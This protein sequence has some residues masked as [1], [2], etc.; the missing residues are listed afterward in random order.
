MYYCGLYALAPR[1]GASYSISFFLQLMNQTK[2]DG[3]TFK[4]GANRLDRIPIALAFAIF[5]AY[6]LPEWL[7]FAKSGAYVL[8][9]AWD[10]ETYLTWQGILGS[11]NSPGYFV[12]YLNWLL[13]LAGLSG[14]VQNLLY[15]TCL[16]PLTVFF[17]YR[18]LRTL[19]IGPARAFAYA[20][21][22]C[23]SSTLFNYANPLVSFLLGSY[24]ATGVFMAGWE[25]YPSI[26]RTP[27]PQ[28]SYLL[29]SAAV[30]GF[31]KFRKPW[32]LALPLPLLYY[33]VA[34]PYV[35]ALTTALAY[36]QMRTRWLRQP[37]IAV[38][39]ATVF[40]FLLIG[41]GM[42][43]LS[44]ATG[45][46]QPDHPYRANSYL[47][48]NTRHVQLPLVLL[49]MAGAYLLALRFKLYHEKS[50]WL[51]PLAVLAGTALGSINLHI[52]M[53]FMLS[54]KGYYDYGLSIIFGLALAIMIDML[55]NPVAR[56]RVL[57]FALATVLV[58]TL[59]SQVYWYTQA[60]RLSRQLTPI[61][62]QVRRDPLHAIIPDLRLSSRVA[63]SSPMLL[64]PPFSYQYYF[65]FIE[66]QCAS[67]RATLKHGLAFAKSQ[68]P[69]GSAD[70]AKL[71][72]TVRNIE[73]GQAE[74]RTLPFGNPPYCHAMDA[75]NGNFM[76][77]SNP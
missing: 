63:Y 64:A 27:N 69:A 28:V 7:A 31:L 30:Y 62:G 73:K 56:D 3:K 58:P 35:F 18:S 5:L 52:I 2:H 33:F 16:P 44:W 9:N 10:E 48:V 11:R 13:H 76:L 74:S 45:L 57:A 36:Q 43:I 37:A 24:D 12:L 23:F 8:V 25:R 55:R 17:T 4:P 70:L 77:F 42:V 1:A 29:I 68:L 41:S 26:L 15:D 34:V 19:D 75:G 65:G 21:L 60:V 49:L 14:A 59:L 50:R 6:L 20:T 71:E 22:I 46:Y 38:A 51:A 54:Q 61:I 47:L 32:L 39:A 66:K 67:Y 72:D 53:G 40:T